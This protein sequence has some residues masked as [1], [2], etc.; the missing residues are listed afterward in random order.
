MGATKHSVWESEEKRGPWTAEEDI[1][2]TKLVQMYG[3]RKWSLIA[4]K[5]PGRT[6]KSSRLR[7]AGQ[8][9]R[10][11]R[12]PPGGLPVRDHPLPDSACG[13]YVL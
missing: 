11:G 9:G 12:S 8:R 4:E 7:C 5:I 3:P 13:S 2:L 10:P 6:G 1:Q